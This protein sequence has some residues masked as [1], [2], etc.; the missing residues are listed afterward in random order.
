MKELR[1]T[2]DIKKKDDTYT[3]IWRARNLTK[4][5]LKIKPGMALLDDERPTVHP[6]FKML[7]FSVSNQI[8][9]GEEL[10]LIKDELTKDK[11]DNYRFWLNRYA[12]IGIENLTARRYFLTKQ[13]FKRIVKKFNDLAPVFGLPLEIDPGLYIIMNKQDKE[14]DEILN[15][16]KKQAIA[17]GGTGNSA[18]AK[19]IIE[20]QYD[21]GF[22]PVPDEVENKVELI[23][24]R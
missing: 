3:F 2:I 4:M 9:P 19:K 1:F 16:V 21:E 20:I 6:R 11:V 8:M 24:N 10:T 14:I 5:P 15:A 18:Q 12:N 17:A 23:R 7:A 13:Q 22:N